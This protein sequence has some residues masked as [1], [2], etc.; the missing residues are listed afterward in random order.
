MIIANSTYLRINTINNITGRWMA[1]EGLLI[2]AW[3]C[4]SYGSGYYYDS[5]LKDCRT[6]CTLPYVR[7]SATSR[8]VL[9]TSAI[10][11]CLS[12]ADNVELKCLHCAEKYGVNQMGEC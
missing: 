5:N 1:Y 8:C 6:S 11:N 7:D 9:C 3:G 2:L 4:S 12:C 10:S